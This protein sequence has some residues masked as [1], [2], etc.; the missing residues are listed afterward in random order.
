MN[1]AA[2][3]EEFREKYSNINNVVLARANFFPR[4][5]AT[6]TISMATKRCF[7]LGNMYQNKEILYEQIL[8]FG[9]TWGFRPIK[10]KGAYHCNKSGTLRIGSK[11]TNVKRR[12]FTSIKCGCEWRVRFSYLHYNL[13]SP[14]IKISQV[15][16][17]HTNGCVL[18]SDQLVTVTTRS[19]DYAKGKDELLYD[20]GTDLIKGIPV[21]SRQ[22]RE[23]LHCV[24]PIRKDISSQDVYNTRMRAKL[25]R[26]KLIQNSGS[27]DNMQLEPRDLNE[28]CKP[29]DDITDDIM[30]ESVACASEIISE[31]MNGEG[32]MKLTC[33]LELIG[34]KCKGFTYNIAYD[35]EE[36]ITDFV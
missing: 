21:S 8:S 10:E 22:I 2:M 28:L 30:D 27:I 25:F 15:C 24:L 5:C 20:I 4:L 26:R 16:D 11:K 18:C 33:M 3:S 34:L 9:R 35:H 1:L 32:K 13:T 7:R 29:L 14:E 23:K 17:E 36:D 6:E 12:R 19:G 31:Y